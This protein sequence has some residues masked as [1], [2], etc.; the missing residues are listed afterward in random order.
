MSAKLGSE[1]DAVRSTSRLRPPVRRVLG[2]GAIA[3]VAG[4]AVTAGYGASVLAAH[5]P[6][7][8][9]SFGAARAGEVH[10]HD[11]A[12]D[13]LIPA[14]VATALAAALARF[15]RHPTRVFTW[16]TGALAVVSLAGPLTASHTTEAIRLLL[17]L[18]HVIAAAVVIPIL[19]GGLA[20]KDRQAIR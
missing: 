11:F 1:S 13:V 7:R 8:A 17:A 18:G 3:A 6:M 2:H 15:A 16:V 14:L 12:I 19:T 5:G 20:T 10:V 4:T 9:G